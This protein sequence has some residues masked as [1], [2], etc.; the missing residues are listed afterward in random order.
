M[1][2]T[3]I[4]EEQYV[5]IKKVSPIIHKKYVNRDQ[6]I[7]NVYKV[8]KITDNGILLS[9]LNDIY[10]NIVD[11]DYPCQL[12]DKIYYIGNN[13]DLDHLK[14]IQLPVIGLYM[15]GVQVEY[16]NKLYFISYTEASYDNEN[17]ILT[18]INKN[19]SNYHLILQAVVYNKNTGEIYQSTQA[20]RDIIDEKNILNHIDQVI[21]DYTKI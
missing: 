15:T 4:Y 14:N 1:S 19:D 13:S 20:S 6:Y 3:N 12:T 16:N 10:W 21:N 17:S 5:R 2:L 9:G 7:G 8:K 18:N 11:F